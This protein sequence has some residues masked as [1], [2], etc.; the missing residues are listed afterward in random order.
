MHKHPPAGA[1]KAARLSLHRSR[2]S[3]GKAGRDLWAWL[4]GTAYRPELHY[5]RGG[6][7]R[8]AAL[9]APSS[10]SC[11]RAATDL[12]RVDGGHIL[13]PAQPAAT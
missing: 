10:G 8:D 5:M 4:T 7:D 12:I 11:V 1:A 9:P 6:A 2:G 13:G 3:A